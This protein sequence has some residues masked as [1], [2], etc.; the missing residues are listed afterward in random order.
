MPIS[1]NAKELGMQVRAILGVPE[2]ILPDE[3]ISSST[4]IAKANNY[5][6]K[7]VSAESL[8]LELTRIAFTYYICYLIAP[9]MYSR[10]PLLM[11]NLS[12]QT[13]LQAV[14]WYKLSFQMLEKCDETINGILEDAGEGSTD[15][16]NSFAVLSSESQ[17]PNT[18]I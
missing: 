5:I 15:G 8:Q 18:L 1:V 11:K 13:Q 9:S 3:V 10:L 2:L 6:S 7:K 12:T 4:F 16:Y 17:Y 14:D